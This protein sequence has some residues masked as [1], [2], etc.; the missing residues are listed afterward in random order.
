[1]AY[2]SIAKINRAWGRYNRAH[3]AIEKVLAPYLAERTSAH[4]EILSADHRKIDS[5]LREMSELARAIKPLW[6]SVKTASLIASAGWLIDDRTPTEAQEFV[7][8]DT[9]SRGI[10]IELVDL[11]VVNGRFVLGLIRATQRQRGAR[12]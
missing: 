5:T 9:H 4:L 12:A 2:P 7:T 8:K 11:Y 6:F 3:R 1:M 10:F